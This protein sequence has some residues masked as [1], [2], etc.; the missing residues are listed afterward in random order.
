MEKI[1]CLPQNLAVSCPEAAPELGTSE[2][3]E[4]LCLWRKNWSRKAE[5]LRTSSFS[6][7][8]FKCLEKGGQNSP[9]SE[10]A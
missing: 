10:H 1:I 4:R 2:G 9:G 7:G 8:A 6:L 5:P 3:S